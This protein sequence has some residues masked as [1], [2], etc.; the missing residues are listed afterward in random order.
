MFFISV[1]TD[2]AITMEDCIQIKRKLDMK[3][4][5]TLFLCDRQQTKFYTPKRGNKTWE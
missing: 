3:M 1:N 4:V 5:K 2:E